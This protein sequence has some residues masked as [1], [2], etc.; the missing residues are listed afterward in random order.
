MHN[1]TTVLPLPGRPPTFATSGARAGDFFLSNGGRR[2]ERRRKRGCR[3]LRME[4]LNIST[5]AFCGV[6]GRIGRFCGRPWSYIWWNCMVCHCV[7][8][9]GE[10]T[11]LCNLRRPGG[12]SCF[13]RGQALVIPGNSWRIIFLF[14]LCTPSNNTIGVE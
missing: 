10:A 2:A 6:H 1:G 9:E 12:N 11:D 8:P 13:R 4:P 5:D 14:L 3:L 7:T